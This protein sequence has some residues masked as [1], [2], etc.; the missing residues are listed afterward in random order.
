VALDAAYGE[1]VLKA[2]RDMFAEGAGK[3]QYAVEARLFASFSDGREE[4]ATL[5]EPPVL[6]SGF[7][8]AT[9]LELEFA[10]VKPLRNAGTGAS[11]FPERGS[12]KAGGLRKILTRSNGRIDVPVYRLADLAPGDCASGPGILEEDYFTCRL[13][14]GWRFVISDVGDIM[15]T[16]VTP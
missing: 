11:G 14:E 4:V 16:R 5:S 3:G 12:A 7:N 10:A 2:S 13:P 9:T 6:P 8:E 15:F 1:L